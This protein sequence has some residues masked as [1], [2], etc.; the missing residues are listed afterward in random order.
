MIWCK[1]LDLLLFPHYFVI[2]THCNIFL[3]TESFRY[4]FNFSFWFFIILVRLFYCLS[5]PSKSG[6]PSEAQNFIWIKMGF[7]SF[8]CPSSLQWLHLDSI[9]LT[10]LWEHHVEP[11][12]KAVP[13][14]RY[15][16]FTATRS[17]RYSASYP[18]KERTKLVWHNR[19]LTNLQQHFFIP[20][21]ISQFFYFFFN[22]DWSVICF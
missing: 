3:C 18:Q 21:I 16:T 17:A 11:C 20:F 10:C 22:A 7:F 9:F 1:F 4:F 12:N 19:F 2:Q 5:T 8:S 6:I 15:L 14:I 13:K